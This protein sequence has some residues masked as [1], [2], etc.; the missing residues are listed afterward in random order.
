MEAGNSS[1]GHGDEH[2]RERRSSCRM[3]V[4]QWEDFRNLIAFD[5][6]SQ[7]YSDCHDNKTDSEDW[8]E[9]TDDLIYRKEGC[10]EEVDEDDCKPE[11]SVGK[12]SFRA[13]L[14]AE[15]A[16]KPCRTYGKYNSHHKKEY[17]RENT[18]NPLHTIS[19]IHS[20]KFRNAE[21]FVPHRHEA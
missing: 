17:C 2:G 4:P 14:L 7:P 20:C 10:N 6:S 13:T 21:T 11:I 18:H 12:D 16:Q 8:I 15:I 1:T 19:H 3:H 5:Y 9:L